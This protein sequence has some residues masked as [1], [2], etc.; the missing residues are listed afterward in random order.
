MFGR[1]K[2]RNII[3]IDLEE[4][5]KRGDKLQ[6]IDVREPSEVASGRIPGAV[7]IPLGQLPQRFGEIDRTRETVVVCRSGMRSTKA[8]KFLAGQGYDNVW[9]LMGGMSGWRGSVQ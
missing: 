2:V 9:N 1:S 7:N 6:I 5:L 4:R 3:P 8:C